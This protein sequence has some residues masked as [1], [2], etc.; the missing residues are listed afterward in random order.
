MKKIL[1]ILLTL[2]VSVYFAGC[3]QNKKLSNEI[4]EPL[5]VQ[6]EG[7]Y[8]LYEDGGSYVQ[9]LTN[10]LKKIANI[11]VKGGWD[12]CSVGDGKVY[13]SIPGD[14]HFSDDILK[15][16]EAGKITK[17]IDLT[18]DLPMEIE[19]NKYN[20]KAYV[21]HKYKL[22]FANENCISII[23]AS[24]D[25]EVDSFMYDEIVQDITFSS[26]NKMYISSQN[27]KTYE[28]QIDVINLSN[29]EIEKRIVIEE[30]LI[31][32]EYSEST[33]LL[34]GVTDRKKSPVLYSINCKDSIVSSLP[35]STDYPFQLILN[36]SEN[37][38]LLY[39]SNVDTDNVDKGHIITV[40]DIIEQ[41]E[42][43]KI[44]SVDGIFDFIVDD[45][46]VYAVARFR[47]KVYKVDTVTN[48]ITTIDIPFPISIEKNRP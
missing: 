13:V 16:I 4:Q 34:Y 31:S 10:D 7:I 41:K 33:Q 39:I 35:I 17:T 45:D 25:Q 3:V 19:Y 18:Y 27:L 2:L 28:A 37:Q 44:E 22:T 9:Y 43:E 40:Y 20:N 36:R 42:I 8:I 26:D 47:D 32:I 23:D 46:D 11:K 29:H 15:V 21:S 38:P 14:A 24:T 48:E 12:L 30:P 6:N 5:N 1:V